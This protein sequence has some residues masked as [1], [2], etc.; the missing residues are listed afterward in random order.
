MRSIKLFICSLCFAL[1]ALLLAPCSLL[2]A[3]QA[4][5]GLNLGGASY[6][7]DLNQYNPVKISGISGGAFAKL[8]FDPH[9]GLGLH[10][11]FGKVKADDAKSANLQFN[12]RNLS[13]STP[14]SEVSL[15]V[16]FNLFDLLSY[17]RKGRITPYLFAGFGILLFNPTTS[18]NGNEVRLKDFTTEGQ[19]EP[20]KGYALTF[21][22]GAGVRYKLMDNWTVFSQIGYRTPLTD[23]IDDVS[24]VYVAPTAF[25]NSID[26]NLS[27]ALADRSG[28]ITGVYLGTPGT[29]RGDFRKRDNYM[30]VGI[31]IS[32]TFVSQK[33][34]TF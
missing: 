11:N 34:F 30:F 23:Y 28:E 17:T 32:Y 5:F 14:L 21:P 15:L 8:N 6:L 4:E 18:Y 29:Q 27:R 9:W 12:D 19:S 3:Q 1:C 16:D 10:Y 22:Y 24:L 13:F 7:G 25:T 31:G 26:P 2:L 33:C 20:Y